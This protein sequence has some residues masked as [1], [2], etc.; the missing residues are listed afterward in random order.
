MKRLLTACVAALLAASLVFVG[1]G[2]PV[3][4]SVPA[5]AVTVA[6]ADS[7][8]SIDIA[9]TVTLTA[10]VTPTNSTDTVS[11]STSDAAIATVTDGVVTGVAAGTATITAT[12]G[13]VKG[14]IDIT[15]KA[16]A[17]TVTFN[18]NGG[19]DVAVLTI[20]NGAKATKPADPTRTGY[21][22]AGWFSD[23]AL[24]TAFDFETALTA[25]TT[26]YAKWT[27]STYTLKFDVN[28]ATGT[29][30]D[31]SVSYDEAVDLSK[32]DTSAIT[33]TGYTFVGWATAKDATSA[34]TSYKVSG[35]A[36]LFMVWTNKATFKVSFFDGATELT[37]L[38]A[39]VIDGSAVS[40]PENSLPTK[41]GYTL[42]GW[43][44]TDGGAAYD[45]ATAVTANL[46]LYALW[47]VNSYTVSF[48]AN[49]GTGTTASVSIAYGASGTLTTNAFTYTDKFFLGWASSK[50]ATAVEYANGGKFKM[51]TAKDVTLYAVWGDILPKTGIAL[52]TAY[53][54]V[55][56]M[57]VSGTQVAYETLN[58]ASD[59]SIA[60]G[61]TLTFTFTVSGASNY[62]QI[63][64]QGAWNDYGWTNN[65]K[66]ASAGIADGTTYTI[67]QS[68]TL[69]SS[70]GFSF[71]LC[72]DN[73]VDGT[74]AA[75]TV[76]IAG[77]KIQYEAPS[78][79]TAVTI[80]AAATVIYDASTNVTTNWTLPGYQY[81]AALGAGNGS[82]VLNLTYN[83]YTYDTAT[84]TL[85]AAL[86]L[87]GKSIYIVFKGQAA[88]TDGSGLKVILVQDATHQS[89]TNALYPTDSTKYAAYSA[90][91]SGFWKCWSS[92]N[93]IVVADLTSIT[94][95]KLAFQ[96]ETAN[97]SIASIYV[98]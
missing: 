28:G 55:A 73:P 72:M 54:G 25:N 19:S 2:D 93:S 50:S 78:T 44:T 43:S 34:L 31:K 79:S 24:T 48:D 30:S 12:A 1:C 20:D 3:P 68:V 83:D 74:V 35:D 97:L 7:V 5:T 95:I 26:L 64:V 80:P 37:D 52:D 77:L 49:G 88:L 16:A 13:D 47:T 36:T 15:V 57:V 71:K 53:S 8:T 91:T 85:P 46:S 45:F 39:T 75:T 65:A 11:W 17:V 76:I 84:Y 70:T 81:T 69:A 96:K 21:V 18:S 42:S 82:Y 87:T 60:V 51:S 86:D 66:W 41:T 9:G 10:T 62:K 4:A 32:I 59:V 56:E 27:A 63:A 94:A 67:T 40:K 89:E 6:A 22:F 58:T 92:D 14:T 33:Y 23:E 98:M 90:A 38:A 61:G 29:I